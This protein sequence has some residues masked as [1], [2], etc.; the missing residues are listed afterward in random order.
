MGLQVTNYN[1]PPSLSYNQ[2]YLKY[3]NQS[4]TMNTYAMGFDALSKAGN[5]WLGLKNYNMA[6]NSFSFNKKLMSANYTN[7]AK[8]YNYQMEQDIRQRFSQRGKSQSQLNQ[9]MQTAEYRRKLAK[10]SL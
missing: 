2:D 8:S 6:K 1:I 5:L 9:Y 3:L 7:S 10:E 4:Q